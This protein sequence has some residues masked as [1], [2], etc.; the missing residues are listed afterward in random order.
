MGYTTKFSG[1]FKLD[2]P[3]DDETYEEL[4]AMDGPFYEGDGFPSQWNQWIVGNDGQSVKW[5]GG[6]AA[7]TLFRP[8]VAFA[9]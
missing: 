5:N 7:E 2:R 6:K 4:A 9:V 1:E 3:L 8:M